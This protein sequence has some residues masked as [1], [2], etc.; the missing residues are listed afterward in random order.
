[1]AMTRPKTPSSASPSRA[2]ADAS[3]KSQNITVAVRVRPLTAGEQAKHNFSTVEVLE[4]HHVRVNDP[5]DKMGGID[6]LRM[7]KTK[8]KHYRFDYAFGGDATQAAVYEATTRPL[9]LKAVEGYNACCFAYGAT[10]AGKTFTMMGNLEQMGVI[11]LTLEDLKL[12]TARSGEETEF[13]ISMQYVEIYNE[14]IKDLLNPTDA[15]LDVREV[16]SKG[17]YVAGATEKPVSSPQEMMEL[18]QKGNLHRTTEA[19]QCNEASSRSHAV[20]QLFVRSKPRYGNGVAKL[21]KL[22]MID[23][24]GSE[25]Q[26]K[27]G[28]AGA[29]LTEGANI[30]RSLLALGNCI[31]ALADRSRRAA[32][33]PYRDSKLTRLLKDSLGGNCLTTMITNVSPAH[34]QAS[35]PH[36]QVDHTHK[37]TT[38]TSRPHTQIDHTPK[39][40]TQVDH[41]HVLHCSSSA[42]VTHTHIYPRWL[43]P[44]LSRASFFCLCSSTRRSI[45]SSTPTAR[46]ISSQETGY[47]LWSTNSSDG[48]PTGSESS[49]S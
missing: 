26:S 23:L 48:L 37:S 14:K 32:H 15:N 38:H 30:N 46:R 41:T 12:I 33:V 11:P 34:V 18:I 9:V 27:T 47:R 43:A 49:R 21:G 36:T 2:D 5:D 6:Y 35:R 16:P 1:M 19:T 20:L 22:S 8:T 42:H 40:I 44:T 28:N 7:D 10:G 4:D 3:T 13:K 25:R 24:A 45:R 39:S 29:R 17:T 31:N